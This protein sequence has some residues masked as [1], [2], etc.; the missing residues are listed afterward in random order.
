MA[1]NGTLSGT[2]TASDTFTFTVQ[3]TDSNAL[4]GSQEYS[5]TVDSVADNRWHNAVVPC[6]VDG[7]NGVT[8]LDALTIINRLNIH[9]D[10]SLPAP[11]AAPPPY[12]DVN[13]DRLCTAPDV[14]LV[15]NVI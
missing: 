6:D 14:L 2:P 9:P 15:I 13:D 12:Y 10:G 5:L 1:S 8:P 7:L 3:A 4:A 11:P